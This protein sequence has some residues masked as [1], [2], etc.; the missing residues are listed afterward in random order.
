QKADSQIQNQAT[1]DLDL[2]VTPVLEKMSQNG[3]LID[4]KF[5]EKMGTDLKAKLQN[6][7]S[8]IYKFVGHEFN[9]NSP[10][11]LSEVLFDELNLPVVRKTKTG[12]STDE[13]TLSELTEAHPAI[14]LLLEYRQLYKL[15][16]TYI[17]ALPK[18]VAEDGR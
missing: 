12:R 10:K 9:L 14:P 6:L 8:E 1:S 7:E 18:S 4:I 2:A 5:L 15:V 17:D 13:A 3:V 11:Q 16:S